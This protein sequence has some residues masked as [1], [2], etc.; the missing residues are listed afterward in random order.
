MGGNHLFVGPEVAQALFH[1]SGLGRPQRICAQGLELPPRGRRE[2]GRDP[3]SRVLRQC[4]WLR[5]GRRQGTVL[6]L[7]QR[8]DGSVHVVHDLEPLK[9]YLAIGLRH[10]HPEHLAAGLPHDH[11][12]GRNARPLCLT[13]AAKE[14]RL[15]TTCRSSA[16]CRIRT[17][18]R[19]ATTMTEWQ[20]LRKRFSL[21][22][23]CGI[24]V[25][26]RRA[27]PRRTTRVMM[28]RASSQERPIRR[29]TV[30]GV[31]SRY[32]TIV[33]RLNSRVKRALG[34]AH[35]TRAARTLW[36]AHRR[37]YV[38]NKYPEDQNKNRPRFDWSARRI[39]K[40]IASYA[41]SVTSKHFQH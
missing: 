40:C 5:G 8:V 16:T 20:R 31:A 30:V 12:D 28:P 13:L 27:R 22:P 21:I 24:T 33:R 15:L 23:R 14:G 38:P 1:G 11:R 10:V 35:G 36:V 32:Q 39:F 17:V 34:S 6:L 25:D 29:A 4:E 3:E 9:D 19:S 41:S 37:S 7:G 2:D 18:S 26:C